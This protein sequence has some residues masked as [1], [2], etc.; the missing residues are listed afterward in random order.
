MLLRP[1]IASVL[2]VCL[3]GCTSDDGR[4]SVSADTHGTDTPVVESADAHEH[5][6]VGAK[7]ALRVYAHCGFEFTQIDGELWKTRLRDD[8]QGNPPAGWTDV[9][10]GT[11]ERISETRAIFIGSSVQIR[12][13]FR[14]APGAKYACA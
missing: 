9:V 8:G 11:V 13:V 6:A 7:A 2:L 3:S 5:L 12:A 4:R 1:L 10:E 14:P